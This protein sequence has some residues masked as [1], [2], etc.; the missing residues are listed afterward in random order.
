MSLGILVTRPAHQA[1]AQAAELARRGYAPILAPCLKI[2]IER[3]PMLDD[4]GVAAYAATSVNGVA[5]LAARMKGREKTLYVVGGASEAAA[6]QAGFTSIERGAGDGAGLAKLIAKRFD[7]KTGALLYACGEDTA[8][9]L[10]A[11][12]EKHTILVLQVALYEMPLVSGL[13]AA[14]LKAIDAGEAKAVL[15]MSARTATAFG[16]LA[17]A[18]GRGAALRKLA[19]FCL[20]EKVAEAAR[21]FDFAR[22]VVAAEPD[23]ASLLAA[24]ETDLPP[25]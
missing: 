7:P 21:G 9:D 25:L 22:V 12:L 14:A 24:L 13:P 6:R 19:A 11:A 10:R 17:A 2:R 8:F 20:S 23:E 5:A 4:D 3:G 18:A 16:D 15:L 1:E